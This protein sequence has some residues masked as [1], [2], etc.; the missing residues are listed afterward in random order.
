MTMK[1]G[2]SAEAGAIQWRMNKTPLFLAG[3]AGLF[4]A[5]VAG[6][7]FLRTA[8]GSAPLPAVAAP[9]APEFTHRDPAEWLNSPPLK[10]EDLR[11]Q[12][13]LLDF[14]TFACWNCYRSFPWLN[15]LQSRL[16]GR[17]LRVIGVHT[18][19][20]AQERVAASVKEKIAVYGLKHP[21]MLD[22]DFSYWNA[23]NNHYWPAY[24]LIDRQGRVRAQYAGE[25]HVGDAQARSIEAAIV[26][27]LDE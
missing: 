16:E 6:L 22:N 9:P 18:P 8:Q 24:Y 21:V 25:T 11:G 13:V 20:L 17:G 4:L 10:L 7:L 23:M 5:V 3:S 14:W 2:P 27:L 15:D 26:A 19:E 12:V 1:S